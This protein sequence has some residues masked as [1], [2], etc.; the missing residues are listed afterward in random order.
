MARKKITRTIKSTD[1]TVMCV[2][3]TTAEVFNR[4]AT[5]VGTFKDDAAALKAYVKNVTLPV[6]EKIVCVVD[7]EQHE[8]LYGI[9]EADF[10][11]HAQPMNIDA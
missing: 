9:S 10:I 3:T 7:T 8:Q 4:S 5:L 6:N 2:N 11:A 1:V